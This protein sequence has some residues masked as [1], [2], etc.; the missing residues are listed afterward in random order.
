MF[1]LEHFFSIWHMLC[2]VRFN[3]Q[4]FNRIRAVLADF[5]HVK[6]AETVKA[7]EPPDDD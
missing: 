2:I 4:P 1:S 6:A 3:S 7:S 5:W